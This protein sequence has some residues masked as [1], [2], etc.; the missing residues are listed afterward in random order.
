MDVDVHKLP[1]LG[2]V[3]ETVDGDTAVPRVAEAAHEVLDPV[4]R[5]LW[6]DRDAGVV[7]IVVLDLAAVQQNPLPQSLL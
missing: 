4:L 5:E 1:E 2:L 6:T 7:G 3:V